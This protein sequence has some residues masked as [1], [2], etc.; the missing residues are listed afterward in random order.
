M[1]EEDQVDS[2]F[3]D[4]LRAELDR[5]QPLNSAPRYLTARAR[6][7]TLRLAPAMLGASLVAIL[8]LSA[9]VATGSPNPA[10]WGRDVVTIIQ[11]SS[12]TPT[13][14]SPRATPTTT[15]KGES[16][17]PTEQPEPREP[18]EHQGSPEPSDDHSGEGASG[19]GSGGGDNTS[20]HDGSGSGG[21][22]SRDSGDSSRES[23]DSNDGGTSDSSDTERS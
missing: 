18:G 14:T 22:D 1:S 5:V 8:A 7:M 17:E 21:D 23:G 20:G 13:P 4:R 11:S 16:P 15:H 10:V 6:P 19:S 2:D 9:F 12:T 3:K